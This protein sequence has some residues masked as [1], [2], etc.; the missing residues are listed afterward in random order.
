MARPNISRRDR[1]L[2]RAAFRAARLTERPGARGTSHLVVGLRGES[3][4]TIPLDIRMEGDPLSLSLPPLLMRAG[5]TGLS[6]PSSSRHAICRIC[7]RSATAPDTTSRGGGG[8]LL[9]CDDFMR[10]GVQAYAYIEPR[11]HPVL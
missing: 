10:V 6:S 5:T 9:S 1:S 3:A 4:S 2:V 11:R 7:A 8:G